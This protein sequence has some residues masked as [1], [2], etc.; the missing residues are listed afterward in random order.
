MVCV[1]FSTI[2]NLDVQFSCNILL[3]NNVTTIFVLNHLLNLPVKQLYVL[4]FLLKH[5]P[6]KIYS[7]IIR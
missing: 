5:F 4:F 2:P 3:L 6:A 7:L 1:V